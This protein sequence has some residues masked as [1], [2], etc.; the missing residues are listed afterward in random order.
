MFLRAD[1]LDP[2]SEEILALKPGLVWLP[3][4]TPCKSP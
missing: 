4:N 3:A 2:I 1:L